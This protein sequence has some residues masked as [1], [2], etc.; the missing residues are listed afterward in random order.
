MKPMLHVVCWVQDQVNRLSHHLHCAVLAMVS[1]VVN[2][3]SAHWTGGVA[4]WI[5]TDAIIHQFQ[6]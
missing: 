6:A 3:S 5:V 2:L 4:A 1:V